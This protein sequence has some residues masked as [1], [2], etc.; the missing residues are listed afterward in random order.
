MAA[1]VTSGLFG[2]TVSS[3]SCFLLEILRSAV[4]PLSLFRCVVEHVRFFFFLIK[5][6]K[7]T[8]GEDLHKKSEYELVNIELLMKSKELRYIPMKKKVFKS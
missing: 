1:D 2:R 5:V 3:G 8:I 7:I 4:R 6:E